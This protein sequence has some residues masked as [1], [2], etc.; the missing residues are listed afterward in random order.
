M[1]RK[2]KNGERESER[3]RLVYVVSFKNFTSGSAVEPIPVSRHKNHQKIE[4][5]DGRTFVYCKCKRP[6]IYATAFS[7]LLFA[8]GFVSWPFQLHRNRHMHTILINFLI[9]NCGGSGNEFCYL[10]MWNTRMRHILLSSVQRNETK[11]AKR[12]FQ[13]I[14]DSFNLRV[15]ITQWTLS[16]DERWTYL[17]HSPRSC[18]R[19]AHTIS[20]SPSKWFQFKSKIMLTFL[21]DHE[22]IQWKLLISTRIDIFALQFICAAALIAH[23]FNY[24]LFLFFSS[25]FFCAHD[26][27]Q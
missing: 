1:N 14:Q 12:I 6:N 16:H 5:C 7:I 9:W 15:S 11:V 20:R 27:I 22:E 8:M 3:N 24:Y 23:A 13:F 21:F 25:L 18:T 4:W 26:R 17:Q 19:F 2:K 10:S